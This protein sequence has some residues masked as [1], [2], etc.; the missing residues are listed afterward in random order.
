MTD[1]GR[2]R[3]TS[4]RTTYPNANTCP[5]RMRMPDGTPIGRCFYLCPAAICPQ[6]GDVSALLTLYRATG[7]LT[8]ER[9]LPPRTYP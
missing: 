1:D 9:K 4:S 2:H 6:H 8:D 5:V 3:N 7:E